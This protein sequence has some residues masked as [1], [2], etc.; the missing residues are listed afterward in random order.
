[1]AAPT[2]L[3]PSDPRL[4]VD[5]MLADAVRRSASDVHV[6]PTADGYELRYRI[7]GLLHPV[8]QLDPTTGRTAVTRLMVM[9]QLLTYRLDVPQEGRV[10]YGGDDASQRPL[11]LRLAVMPTT[12]GLRAAI[13]LPAELDRPLQLDTL[14]LPDKVLQGLSQFTKADS[15]MLLLTGPAGSGKTTT[16]HALLA[17]L[18][19]QAQGISI[20]ALEDPVERDLPGVTQIEVSRFGELTYERALRSILRQDPQV[21][22]IGEIRD[23]ATASL[24]VQAA[25]SGHR[26]VSTLHAAS[27]GGAVSRLLEMGLEPYQITSALFAV[28]AQRL[29]RRRTGDEGV[30]RGRA[31][32]ASIAMI[33]NAVRHAI[34]QRADAAEIGSLFAAQPL[35][36][37]LHDAAADLVRSGVTDAAEVTRVLGTPV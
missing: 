9:A 25:L 24:A 37:S 21:L 1:M 6:E 15:G 12:H 32:V 10:R 29:L 28:V 26:V 17:Q 36:S 5:E 4:V 14:T 13:R 33:D 27:P 3:P 8:R 2:S 11:E 31:P 22:M 20:I 23:A 19:S 18:A 7:D 30:Y 35:Y 16:I 34:L